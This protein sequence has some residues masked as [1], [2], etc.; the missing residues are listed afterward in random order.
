MYMMTYVFL[1]AIFPFKEKVESEERSIGER[2]ML[3][4][5]SI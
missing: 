4:I 2:S 3:D 1:H 5:R